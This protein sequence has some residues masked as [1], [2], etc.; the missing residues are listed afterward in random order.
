[1]AAGWGI[2]IYV[3]DGFPFLRDMDMR[4]GVH[5]RVVPLEGQ[6]LDVARQNNLLAEGH[7]DERERVTRL[8]YS[9]TLIMPSSITPATSH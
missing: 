6:Q 8:N 4:K 3:V 5:V 9:L 2:K 1:M 7:D